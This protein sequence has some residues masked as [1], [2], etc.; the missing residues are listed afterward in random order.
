MSELKEILVLKETMM[1][2]HSK[3]PK[4]LKITV[5]KQIGMEM[6]TKGSA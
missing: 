5:S 6:K 2:F 4:S 3:E 1:Y